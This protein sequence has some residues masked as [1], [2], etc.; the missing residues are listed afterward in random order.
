MID[1]RFF[2]QHPLAFALPSWK[3]TSFSNF[4]LFEI[5]PK[6]NIRGP[7]NRYFKN[8]KTDKIYAVIL[9]GCHT[10]CSYA[11]KTNYYLAWQIYH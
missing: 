7:Q 2:L 11:I 5:L 1:V 3:P 9:G 10:L 6:E 4:P 8:E